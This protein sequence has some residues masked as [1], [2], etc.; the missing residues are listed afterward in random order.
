M[1][2][3]RYK[4]LYENSRECAETAE[5]LLSIVWY[6]WNSRKCAETA[7]KCADMNKNVKQQRMCWN[8]HIVLWNSRECA[9]TAEKLLSIVWNGW[10][11]RECAETADKCADMNKQC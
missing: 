10:N 1:C 11:S 6:G 8:I 3:N 4:W 5:K 2:W 7:D 9:E